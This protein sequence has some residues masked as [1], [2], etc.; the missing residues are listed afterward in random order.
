MRQFKLTLLKAACILGGLFFNACYADSAKPEAVILNHIPVIQN[1][2]VSQMSLQA[3]MAY[4]KVPAISFAVIENNQIIWANASGFINA[5]RT[6]AVN[7]ETLFQA[8]SMSK[9]V[10][11]ITALA[12]VDQGVL[13]LDA[14]VNPLLK[15]WQI[16]QAKEFSNAVTLR[17]LLSMSSGLNGGGYYGYVPG[18]PLPSVIQ[19][20]QGAGPAN[21]P[22]VSMIYQ[23]GTQYY[24]SGAGYEVVELLINSQ[25]SD[26][27]P[28]V[29]KK[30]LFTP[31]GMSQSHYQ[32]PLTSALVQNAAQATDMNGNAFTYPWRVVPEYAAGGLWST[33][34]DLAKML[35][36]LINIWQGKSHGLISQ[37]LA[38]TALSPQQNTPYGLG[39]VVAGTG[40]TLHFMKL[41]QNAGYQGWLVGYPATGQGIVVMTNSDNGRELAQDLIFA[42]AKAYHWPTD[43]QV[44]DEGTDCLRVAS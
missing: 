16:P 22:P 43:G 13:N 9:P 8:G 32:Q 20:L 37:K 31:L 29:V 40:K 5:A 6:Q 35:I 26:S 2:K 25:T 21:N 12:L 17:E 34:T 28:D 11:A 10:A 23:P 42:V 41:G 39:F 3:A 38:E 4:F 24:Y 30:M 7:T 44:C 18:A 15:G 1:G 14:P 33:P 27:F 19:T 36:E